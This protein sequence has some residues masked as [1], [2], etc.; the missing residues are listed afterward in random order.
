MRRKTRINITIAAAAF[1]LGFGGTVLVLR[2]PVQPLTMASLDAARRR[3]ESTA[4]NAYRL[5]YRMHGSEYHV[6]VRDGIVT[7][8]T[9]DG[10]VSSSADYGSYGV[11]GLFETLE[12]DIENFTDPNGPLRGGAGGIIMRARFNEH[13]GYVER[14]LRSGGAGGRGVAIELIEFT[15][16]R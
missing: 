15:P 11:K 6:T 4:P 10:R 3:W 12:A 5:H 13:Y 2:E 1:V 8:L 14:Y 9:V 7:E 16:V